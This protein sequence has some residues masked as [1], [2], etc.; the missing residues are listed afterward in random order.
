MSSL[1]ELFDQIRSGD[2]AAAAPL[3]ERFAE[4]LRVR[5]RRVAGANE[6]E[7]L[8]YRTLIDV[9][10][11]V[12]EAQ[13]TRA[14]ELPAY[15]RAVAQAHVSSRSTLA[16][17]RQASA[18]PDAAEAMDRVLNSISEQAREI[19]LRYYQRGQSVQQIASAMG[20]PEEMILQTKRAARERFGRELTAGHNRHWAA[21]AAAT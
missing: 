18:T 4:G 10:R 11:G 16:R 8:V 21:A 12:K 13:L 19:L 15:V 7:E 1:E 5:L 17:L 2:P 14:V 6:I 9:A 20:L 3:Y